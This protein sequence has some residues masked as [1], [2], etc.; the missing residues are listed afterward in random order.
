MATNQ[1][2]IRAIFSLAEN[3]DHDEIR[4][5]DFK[6]AL[7]SSDVEIPQRDVSALFRTVLSSNS[8]ASSSGTSTNPTVDDTIKSLKDQIDKYQALFNILDQF[9]DLSSATLK[10]LPQIYNASTKEVQLKHKLFIANL[11]ENTNEL[12]ESLRSVLTGMQES[13]K[14]SPKYPDITN[15]CGLPK[16]IW[17]GILDHF[18]KEELQVFVPFMKGTCYALNVIA[19]QYTASRE[20]YSRPYSSSVMDLVATTGSISCLKFLAGFGKKIT[21][22][23]LEHAAKSG[24]VELVKY[25]HGTGLPV[26]GTAVKN[27]GRSGNFECF[28][29]VTE[30]VSANFLTVNVD[31]VLLEGG[32]IDSIR[33]A[34]EKE[35]LDIDSVSDLKNLICPQKHAPEIIQFFLDQ[36]APA[37]EWKND[38][39]WTLS[40]CSVGNF[41][42]L[43]YLI[44]QG[45]EVHEECAAQ[46]NSFESVKYLWER[47]FKSPGLIDNA[48]RLGALDILKFGHEVCGYPLTKYAADISVLGVICQHT[49]TDCLEYLLSKDCPYDTHNIW[50]TEGSHGTQSTV[51]ILFDY[52]VPFNP[53]FF[54]E[55]LRTSDRGDLAWWVAQKGV[56]LPDNICDLAARAGMFELLKMA[57]QA[58][59]QFSAEIASEAAR[60]GSTDCLLYVLDN[61]AALTSSA[62]AWAANHDDVPI[63]AIL[64]ERECP[65]PDEILMNF[66]YNNSVE[67][68]RYFDEFFEKKKKRME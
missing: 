6:K 4:F 17:F 46:A 33:Y 8:R 63:L 56:P 10:D 5:Q 7:H 39:S 41:K 44:E 31:S 62:M 65:V 9:K 64:L 19:Y 48:A 40:A 51:Q 60:G 23:T 66:G 18:T 25:I 20:G 12:S 47:G 28:K 2:I 13:D 27:A 43:K 21:A 36:G 37:E 52:N 59:K 15:L 58:G 24:N 54:E 68:S 50:K 26:S 29:Y 1:D 42:C 22:A 38:A 3:T 53:V 49:K 57:H 35:L 67:A 11:Y 30:T 55:C 14:K 32:N 16:E 45:F 61:G 34:L